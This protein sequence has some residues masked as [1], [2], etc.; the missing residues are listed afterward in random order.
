MEIIILGSGTGIPTARRSSPGLVVK[1][2]EKPILFDSGSGS[3]HQLSLA[4]IDYHQ[5]HYLF[6]THFFHPDH[7]NDLT[8][9]LFA[10][11]YDRPE[12]EKTLNIIGPRGMKNFYRNIRRLF[13]LFERMPF[14]VNIQEVMDDQI[15]LDS[16]IITSKPLFHQEVDCVGY[17]IES[18][19]KVVIY[20]GDTDY[21][22]N[23]IELGKDADLLISEC[24]FPDQFKVAGHLSPRLAGEIA[25][26]TRAKQLLLTH[27]YPI[28]DDYDI[29]GEVKNNFSG[30]VMVAEDLMRITI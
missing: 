4:G 28:C 10:N 13:P 25:T 16:A 23:L 6:Y 24:S 30:E 15:T 29:R 3:L 17:R 9:I 26:K 12:R 8:A 19:G 18:G 21:C 14:P 1:T 7:V 11:K 22:P 2:G 5:I 20:T 27:L